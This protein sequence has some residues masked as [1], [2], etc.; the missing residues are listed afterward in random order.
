MNNESTTIDRKIHASILR[1]EKAVIRAVKVLADLPGMTE[2]NAN[3]SD[4]W[5]RVQYDVS[6][7]LFHHLI[8]ALEKAGLIRQQGWWERFKF[9][10]YRNQDINMRDNAA[11]RQAPCC[12]NPEEILARSRKN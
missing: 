8:M 11:A 12:S 10:S 7:L 3:P 2:V 5:I 6:K 4:K 1:D 9:S